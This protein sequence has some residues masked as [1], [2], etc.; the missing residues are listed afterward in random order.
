MVTTKK[1]I[2][3]LLK[4]GSP[5]TLLEIADMLDKKPKTI[6]RA[7]RKLFE[8]EKIDCDPRTRRYSLPKEEK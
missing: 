8:K 3:Q 5:L 2:L 4:E 7:L 6:F 1:Q